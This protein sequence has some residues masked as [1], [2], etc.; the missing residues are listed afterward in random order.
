MPSSAS[1]CIIASTSPTISRISAE[2]G[3]SNRM[4]SG[5]I[6]SDRTMAMRCFCRR[7]AARDARPPYP[8]DRC[9]LT[10]PSRAYSL[11]LLS[12]LPSFYRGKHDI[13]QNRHV[14]KQVELLKH[15]AD[16]LPDMIDV[17]RRVRQRSVPSNS[18]CPAVGIS[19]RFASAK[20]GFTAAGRSNQRQ[21]IALFDR[22][23]DSA[24]HSMTVQRSCE[25]LLLQN[26]RI[27]AHLAIISFQQ[28]DCL[29]RVP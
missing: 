12:S 28:S 14:R 25:A 1:S 26:Y 6:A 24:Q 20:R 9:A 22:R 3:S 13:F 17:H 2:V 21:H 18:T 4:M 10:A 8:P 5:S 16:L 7:K 19:N 15:H 27:I 29:A 23:R 11:P